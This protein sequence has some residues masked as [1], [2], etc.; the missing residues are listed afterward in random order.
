MQSPS[1]WHTLLVMWFIFKD[2]SNAIIASY[3][4]SQLNLKIT[5]KKNK[6]KKGKK[7]AIFTAYFDNS[8]I[9]KRSEK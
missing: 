2:V 7:E 6:M 3:N 8:T 1:F 5:N 4:F 9:S